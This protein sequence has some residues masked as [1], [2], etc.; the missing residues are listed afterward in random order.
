MKLLR[1]IAALFHRD[2]E[3]SA[4]REEMQLHMDL[5]ARKLLQMG[6]APAD[7]GFAAR[8]QFGNAAVYQDQISALWG[9]TMWERFFQDLRH[10]IRML[11]KA[12]GFTAITVLTLALGLG[13]N[14][15][16]F[17]AVNAVMLRPLP[18]P[19]PERLVS[20]WEE[21]IHSQDQRFSS[22]GT[23]AGTAGGSARTTVS[24]ANIADYHASAVFDDMASYDSAPVNLT[25]L[26]A[27]QRISGEA[28]TWNYFSV[29]GISP[30]EGRTFLPEEDRPGANLVAIIS[31]EFW[32]Q[33]LGGAADA[34]ERQVLLDGNPYRIAGILPAGFQSPQEL[35]L[36]TPTGVYLTACYPSDQLVNRGDH[37]VN[38]I[39]RLKPGVSVAA[40][41]AALGSISSGLG[42]QY[43]VTNGNIRAATALL[44]DD[45]AGGVSQSLW[46]LLGASGVM[47]L[48][49]C[50]NVANL[51]SEEHTSE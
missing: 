24:V 18:Y 36:K 38:V 37:D 19:Q 2:A 41:Q 51:R 20:L 29:L 17:S 14:T 22:S 46:A 31:H 6:L 16:I 12:P 10:G 50:V 40:A 42:K 23:P 35:G 8:R 28:V 9:W 21:T 27:P 11:A 44:R 25:G 15:A 39:A 43:P 48:I 30:A 1:R 7:A 26:G 3:T 45:L 4:L 47:V 13:I 33:R 49:A 32:Q 34:L 5:R